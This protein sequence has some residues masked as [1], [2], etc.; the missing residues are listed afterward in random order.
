MVKHNLQ[1]I[2]IIYWPP[3]LDNNSVSR[4]KSLSYYR[5]L[6]ASPS[7]GGQVAGAGGTPH[8]VWKAGKKFKKS[9]KLDVLDLYEIDKGGPYAPFYQKL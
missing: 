2:T 1:K 5:H 6:A 9:R 3:I 7:F 8:I 4:F